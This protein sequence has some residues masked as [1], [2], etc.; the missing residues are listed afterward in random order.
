MP[1]LLQISRAIDALNRWAGKF[2]IWFILASTLI[3]AINAVVRKAFNMSSN[4]YL[5]VQWY[6]FAW[7]FLL[8]AGYTLLQQEHVKIDVLYSRFSRRRQVWIDIL[9]IVLFLT[10]ICLIVLY[11]GIPMFVQ[12]LQS[13]EM[14]TNAG[15]LI[16]WPVWLAMPIGFVLLMLQG[17]SELIKRVAFLRGQAPDPADKGEEKSAEQEL[18]ESIAQLANRSEAAEPSSAPATSK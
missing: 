2:V 16:R 6:L 7:A 11:F 10:P 13:G 4:A 1:M 18:A 5:E 15:G 8:A 12:K 9:G 17:W 3:S 14:S